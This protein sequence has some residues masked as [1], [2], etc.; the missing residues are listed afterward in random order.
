PCVA[1]IVHKFG[2]FPLGCRKPQIL[3]IEPRK[4]ARAPFVERPIPGR[5]CATAKTAGAARRKAKAAGTPLRPVGPLFPPIGN[6]I[7]LIA[8]LFLPDLPAQNGKTYWPKYDK[9]QN[10]REDFDRFPGFARRASAPMVLS[11]TPGRVGLT[12][13]TAVSTHLKTPLAASS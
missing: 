7:A 10:H 2:K 4:F 6:D 8:G 3:L 5:A 12:R 1:E 9:A 13:D 11:R